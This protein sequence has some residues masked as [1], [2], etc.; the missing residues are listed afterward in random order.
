MEATRETIDADLAVIVQRRSDHQDALMA[1][2]SAIDECDERI[3]ELFTR[4]AEAAK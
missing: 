2:L 3:E 4:R 1:T